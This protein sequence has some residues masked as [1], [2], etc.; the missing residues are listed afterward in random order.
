M[1]KRGF[2]GSGA[3]SEMGCVLASLGLCS[4]RLAL[5]IFIKFKDEVCL[6]LMAMGICLEVF[7]DKILMMLWA[8]HTDNWVH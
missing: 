7:G 1:A 2:L 8:Y 5:Q 3:L 4:A 6:S